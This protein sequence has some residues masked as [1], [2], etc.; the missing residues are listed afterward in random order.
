MSEGAPV[1]SSEGRLSELIDLPASS[2][3]VPRLLP[4]ATICQMHTAEVNH[5]ESAAD[6]EAMLRFT[7]LPKEAGWMLVTVGVVGL[8]LPGIL[9]T[10]FLLAG[11]VVVVPS[12]RKLLSRWVGRNPPKFVGSA[13][14]QID[15]FIDDLDRR[16]PLR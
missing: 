11:T 15:R 10:P 8:V 14:R 3:A 4:T 9:G 1:R 12:G 7:Q 16:Y 2:E 6:E 13:M 5:D